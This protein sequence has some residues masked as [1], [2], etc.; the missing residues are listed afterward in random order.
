[1]VADAQSGAAVAGKGSGARVSYDFH[2]ASLLFPLMD[3]VDLQRLGEDLR[4]HGLLEPIVLLD[5]QVLDGRNRLR[6]CELVEVEPRFVA[7]ESN[8]LTP[9]EWVVSMNLHRRH[10][11]TAQRA[12]LALDLLPHLEEEARERQGARTDIE[13]SSDNGGKFGEATEKA[14]DLVGVGR[15]TVAAAKAIQKRDPEI[16]NEMKA[17]T[18][19][20]AE[21]SRRAG[22]EKLAQAQPPISDDLPTIHY[23]KGD[24]FRES[25]EPLRRYLKAWAGR[26]YEFRHVN[27]REATK[28]LAV[29]NEL[30]DGIEAARAD[31]ATRNTPARMRV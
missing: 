14:A 10:L 6:A 7:W 25:T 1:M 17:G 9:A 13:P 15:S 26:D 30:S 11:T 8:G 22:F 19:T 2:P 16:V 4:E 29:L 27:P 3:G 20:V 5:E 23:G 18:L 21:A 28:R 12:A 24:K 31:L